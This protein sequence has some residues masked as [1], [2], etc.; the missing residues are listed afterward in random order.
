MRFPTEYY[1]MKQTTKHYMP[2]LRESQL[3]GLTVEP[4]CRHDTS[5]PRT[6]NRTLWYNAAVAERIFLSA[7]PAQLY[8]RAFFHWKLMTENPGPR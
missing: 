3:K 8:R 2:H 5:F 4:V 6:A 7:D 1:Q